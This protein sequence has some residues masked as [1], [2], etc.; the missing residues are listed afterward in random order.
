MS[1]E[2]HID[3]LVE[4]LSEQAGVLPEYWDIFGKRH[5]ATAA[6]KRSILKAMRLAVDDE[7]SAAAALSRL[8][9]SGMQRLM[10][11]VQ[12]VSVNTQP[13]S[14]PLVLPC[15]AGALP[16]VSVV[17]D[18]FD[19][20]GGQQSLSL[21][22][23][24]LPVIGER[25]LDDRPSVRTEL[26]LE[27]VL[28]RG[29]FDLRVSIDMGGGGASLQARTRLIVTP[30]SCYRPE[31]P[32]GARTWG[33]A[34]N[35]YALRSDRNWGVG[36]ISDL[37]DL[38][39]R[40]PEGCGCIGLN[41]LH[42]IPN[43][44]PYGI[45]P[46][47]PLSRLY[48]NMV[49]IDVDA[50]YDVKESAEAQRV[51]S[52]PEFRQ[53]IQDLRKSRL[54]DYES[55]A[56]AKDEILRKAFS[57]FLANHYRAATARG[58]RFQNY[59]DQ[60][61]GQLISFATYM[62]LRKRFIDKMSVYAWQQWPEEF[63]R[64]SSPAVAAFREEH[65]D[66]VL[67]HA[68]LQWCAECQL[69]EAADL[70]RER[71]MTAGLYHD[72][73]VGSVGGGSDAWIFGSCVADADLGAPPD[74]FN[75]NGQNWGFPPNIPAVLQE[76]GYE[77]FIQT[78]RKNMRTAGALRIDHALGLYRQYWIPFGVSAKE[79]AYV[80]QPAEDLLRI[81]ALESERN[82][83]VVIAEDLGTIDDTFREMLQSF[84]MLSYRLFYFER[85]Y[86][87]PAFRAPDEYPATA[88]C[89]VTTHDLPTLYGYWQGRDIAVKEEL[90]I[91][92]DENS[93]EQDRESRRRDRRLVLQALR[94]AGLI[95]SDPDDDMEMSPQLC[96]AVYAY[97]AMT[98]CRIAL[99][100]L[101]DPLGVLDQQNLPGTVDEHPNWRQKTP[102]PLS[103]I[104]NDSRVEAVF[105]EMRSRRG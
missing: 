30:D 49:Y 33:L 62:V 34:V 13:I 32:A 87:D 68:Y 80:R 53:R 17:A 18:L 2:R 76:G 93:A 75:P 71:G 92:A 24:A 22:R 39:R 12:V 52:S 60:E 31:D 61:G 47:S 58:R 65:Q 55:A 57:S 10:H 40:L 89:A 9:M 84:G 54:V 1:D 91:Y 46:Y 77:P 98:K 38:I 70:C 105:R 21:Q 95:G 100:S 59:L 36:D 8:T 90:G 50:V 64:P 83:T 3:R 94:D 96:A 78:I 37:K 97:L 67:Y 73:A 82:R 4:E 56:A 28:E 23:G 27:T 81:I 72:L 63:Q 14:V 74:D 101:D 11:P 99:V 44:Q 66:E 6:T 7:E 25:V 85:K 42:C 43:T 35:L 45:S 15:A 102:E 26:L 29:Y 88:L 103:E 86:P 104:L 51:L 48:R 79:G 16:S 5:V 69:Q 41:P 19:E 20:N